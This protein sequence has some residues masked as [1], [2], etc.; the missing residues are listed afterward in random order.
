MMIING[1]HLHYSLIITAR[2]FKIYVILTELTVAVIIS[3]DD[4]CACRSCYSEL[5][6]PL[7]IHAQHKLVERI[8]Q[9]GGNPAPQ[10]HFSAAVAANNGLPITPVDYAQLQLHVEFDGLLREKQVEPG[11]VK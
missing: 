11:K 9:N 7:I 1:R 8:S 5:I 6:S 2:R 10:P 3:R 4:F